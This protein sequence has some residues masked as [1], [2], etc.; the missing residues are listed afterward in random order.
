[1]ADAADIVYSLYWYLGATAATAVAILLTC[2]LVLVRVLLS[3][4]NFVSLSVRPSVCHTG[5]SVKNGAS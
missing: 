4:R 1:M 3:H 2:V 5:D